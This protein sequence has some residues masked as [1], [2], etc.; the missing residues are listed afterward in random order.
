MNVSGKQHFERLC[1]LE[2]RR[3]NEVGRKDSS[4]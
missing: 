4:R 2:G 1:T 3:V